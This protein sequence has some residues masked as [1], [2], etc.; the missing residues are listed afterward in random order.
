[1]EYRNKIEDIMLEGKSAITLGKFDGVHAGHQKLIHKVTEKKKEGFQSVLF[2]FDKPVGAFLREFDIAV[3]LTKEERKKIL[4]QYSLDYVIECEFT[5]EFAH[6]EA[7][8]FIEEILVKRLKVGYIAVGPD[9]TFGYQ[10]KGS[11]RMLQQFG[12]EYGFE[13]EVVDKLTYEGSEISST[14]IRKSIEA[15]KIEEARDM[16]GYPYPVIGEVVHGKKLGRTLGMPTTNL[17][18][19]EEK[20]LPPYGVYATQ[21]VIDGKCYKGVTN[22]GSKPTVSEELLRG[23]ETYIFD[24]EDD[25]YGKIIEID[26]LWYERPEL[27]FDSVETLKEKMEQDILIVRKYFIDNPL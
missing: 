23:V 15:G 19:P 2:T 7:E 8:A 22:I 13:V 10:A 27:K 1:M 12:K 16:L 26:L 25:L 14:R 20:L 9:C 18:P 11:Y 5:K 24:Y 21:I 17:V 4:G 6:M 3:L